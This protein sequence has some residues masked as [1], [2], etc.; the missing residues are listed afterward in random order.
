[1]GQPRG[2]RSLLATNDRAAI[3]NDWDDNLLPNN[4]TSSG[5]QGVPGAGAPCSLVALRNGVCPFSGPWWDRAIEK[6]RAKTARFLT[7]YR[8]A[9]GSLDE[10]VQD[11]ELNSMK[12]SAVAA[13]NVPAACAA[14]DLPSPA[15]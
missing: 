1:M 7:A 3:I 6:L 10:M 14:R 13:P 12:S 15:K 4:G 2:H 11:S 5:C 8:Q 9:A